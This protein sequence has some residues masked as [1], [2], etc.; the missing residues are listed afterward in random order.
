MTP[1]PIRLVTATLAPGDAIGNYIISLR[2]LLQE[3]GA[4]VELYADQIAPAYRWLARPS[5]FYPRGGGGLLWYH[6]SIYSENISLVARSA[7]YRLLDY[8]GITP[9][10]LFSGENEQLAALCR[11]ALEELPAVAASSDYLVAHSSFTAGQLRRLGLENVFEFPLFVDTARF[12]HDD[13]Q[14]AALLARGQYLLF[15]GRIVPQKDIG[16]L[17][18]IFAHVHSHLPDLFLVLAGSRDLLP[19]YQA[20]LDEQVAALN[21]SHRVLF[22]G[23]VNDAAILGALYRHARLTIIASA[24]ESFCVPVAESLAFGTPVAVN[25]VP[26]L[27]E[28]GGPA[29]LVFDR[30]EPDMAAR[31]IVAL[32]EDKAAYAAV[33]EATGRQAARYSGAALAANIRR[34]LQRIAADLAGRPVEPLTERAG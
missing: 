31:Q 1:L 14:L 8:H 33:Q 24:W 23:Q 5:A 9:P 25:D 11:R 28:V 32:L 19:G 30:H 21:L 2:R 15:V 13:E 27:P 7:D 6:Y 20:A 16:S 12:R 10:H 26:P 4:R 18:D 29:A 17:L 34:L 3:W 22:T